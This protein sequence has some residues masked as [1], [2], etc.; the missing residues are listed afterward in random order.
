MDENLPTR[1][2]VQ[3]MEHYWSH[4]IGHDVLSPKGV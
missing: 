3:M 4:I 2:D 1:R